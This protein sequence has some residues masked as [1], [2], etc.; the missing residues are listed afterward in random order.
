MWP[1]Y[2]RVALLLTCSW[3]TFD[4]LSHSASARPQALVCV[5]H[6][7]CDIAQQIGGNALH[8]TVLITA[9]GLDPHHLRPTPSLARTLSQADAVLLNGATYDDWALSLIPQNVHLFNMAQ[10]E[11]NW[12]PG[13]DPHLF[14]DPKI[15]RHAAFNI[16][17]WLIT[18]DPDHATEIKGRLDQFTEQTQKILIRLDHLKAHFQGTTIA[19]TEP[20]GER[21]LSYAGLTIVDRPWALAVMNE[22]GISARDT[23]S[24]E[25]NIT[26]HKI[27]FL[28]VNPT[29]MAPEVETIKTLAN[30]HHIPTIEL[31]ENLPTGQ[32][33]QGWMN[34]TLDDIEHALNRTALTP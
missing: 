30:A 29:V 9:S 25:E 32:S 11:G 34:H 6:V 24:L 23:A 33:W 3:L 14:F 5:E 4:G 12:R 31:G 10:Q 20:A 26:Q 7:W 1:H 16:A 2:C 18:K 19:I 21:L 17:Q 22:N 13:D 27:R 28:L 8:T 15:V